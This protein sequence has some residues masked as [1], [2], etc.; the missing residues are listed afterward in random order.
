MTDYVLDT[1]ACVF[2]LGAPR[3]LGRRARRVLTSPGEHRFW[4]PA[5]AAAEIALL[6]ELGRIELGLPE[7]RTAMDTTSLRF[8]DLT[9]QQLDEFSSL[10]SIRDPFD[11]LVVSAARSLGAKLITK[12]ESLADTGLVDVVW[13]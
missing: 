12:D 10:T 2:A 6:R 7:I 1:H 4:L 3:R 9:W 8:L 13:S 11:R 5:A